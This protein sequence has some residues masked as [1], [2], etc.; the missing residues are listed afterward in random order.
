M[1][2]G[3]KGLNLVSRRVVNHHFPEER[4]DV[5]RENEVEPDKEVGERVRVVILEHICVNAI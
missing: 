5:L 1:K 4:V 2:H 3:R